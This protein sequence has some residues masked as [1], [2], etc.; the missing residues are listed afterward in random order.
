MEKT[1]KNNISLEELSY[2]AYSPDKS[3]RRL[4]SV[5]PLTD[6][7]TLSV[8][9]KD[10]DWVVRFCV[11]SHANC[12]LWTLF[13]MRKDPISYIRCK[14]FSSPKASPKLLEVG[15]TDPS[16]DVRLCVANNPH[17]SLGTLAHLKADKDPE[18]AEAARD[19]VNYRFK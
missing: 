7:T 8:L 2:M 6:E 3:K 1:S 5:H 9:A 4:V 12:S 18:V 17:T 14:V 10:E 19:R 15:A 13:S 11:P 16:P